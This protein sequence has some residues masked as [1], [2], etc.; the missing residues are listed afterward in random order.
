MILKTIFLGL[1]SLVVSNTAI[2]ENP[3]YTQVGETE[4][5]VCKATCTQRF[6]WKDGVVSEATATAGGPFTSC[7]TAVKKACAEA[8]SIIMQGE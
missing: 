4:S 1:F 5:T 6:V 2:V 3:K 8:A 7:K